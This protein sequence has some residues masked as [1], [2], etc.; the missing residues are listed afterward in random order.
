MDR[1]INLK[2]IM[3]GLQEY[4]SFTESNIG[5]LWNAKADRLKWN[6]ID[7]SSCTCNKL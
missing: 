1:Q 7:A 5:D 3:Q 6:N 2:F 4:G